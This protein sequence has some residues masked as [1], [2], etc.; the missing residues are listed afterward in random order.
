MVQLY[1]VRHGETIENAEGVLQGLMPGN[2][3]EQGKEQAQ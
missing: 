1:L 2:L 3:S